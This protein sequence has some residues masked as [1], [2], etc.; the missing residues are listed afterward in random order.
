MRARGSRRRRAGS[1]ASFM[2]RLLLILLACLAALPAAAHAQD[3]GPVA[4]VKVFGDPEAPPRPV[5]PPL[6]PGPRRSPPAWIATAE[7]R[8]PARPAPPLPAGL[9]RAVS[10]GSTFLSAAPS[11]AE[12]TM[13]R[14]AAA[15]A[16]V[17]R[18]PMYWSGVEKYA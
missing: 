14:G 9:A 2:T 4:P 8:P 10:D 13:A 3:P 7:P 12:T 1:P 16:S 6:A 18:M 11:L 5:G 17:V 15:G